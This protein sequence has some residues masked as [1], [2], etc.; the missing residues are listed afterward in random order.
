MGSL[1]AC[2]DGL[3]VHLQHVP[4]YEY[5]LDGFRYCPA[6][7]YEHQPCNVDI[8]LNLSL[9]NVRCWLLIMATTVCSVVR[10]S[11]C[12]S[13]VFGVVSGYLA[14]DGLQMDSSD[15]VIYCLPT[16]D[17]VVLV[18][19]IDM[20]SRSGHPP[21]SRA[22]AAVWK[23]TV[24]QQIKHTSGSSNLSNTPSR[25]HLQSVTETL[26]TTTTLASNIGRASKSGGK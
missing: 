12:C 25:N 18:C 10:F 21:S 17:E 23:P 16:L 3:S 4:A 8:S 6:T 24:E 2:A 7:R 5:E 14:I 26:A 13:A 9:F 11:S 1:M 22:G 15:C 20:A 19:V